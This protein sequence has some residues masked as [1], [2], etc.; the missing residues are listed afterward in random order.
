[1]VG[2]EKAKESRGQ[3]SRN[4]FQRPFAIS[5]RLSDWPT[6]KQNEAKNP[7][8]NIEKIKIQRELS[9]APRVFYVELSYSNYHALEIR[10]YDYNG[11]TCRAVIVLY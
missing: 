4:N 11:Y 10:Y 2:R 8:S 1:M 7:R 5:S 9:G 3:M 6:V